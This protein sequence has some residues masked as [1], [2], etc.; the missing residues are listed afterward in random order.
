MLLVEFE[1]VIDPEVN[2][3]AIRLAARLR[4]RAGHVVRDVVSSYCS[5]GVH[6][7]PLLTDLA[8]L[9]R[10]IREESQHVRRETPSSTADPI[11]IAVRYGGNDGPDLNA[12]AEWAR[13]SPSEVVERH[14]SR[15][16]R[17]YMLG[18]VPGFAYMGRVDRLI[19]GPRHRVP[20][21][22]VPAGSVGIAG[23]QTGVYPIATPGGW[24][25]IGQTD[26]VMFDP[27]RTPASLVQP[28]DR[29]RF[30]PVGSV[31]V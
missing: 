11:E 27:D 20:R 22:R 25:L 31:R 19:A 18:F 12:L 28:G 1:Q 3:Q 5:I 13:C 23:E 2:D 4:T 24:Q 26:V 7:D 14:A 6:F 16:Y 29:V 9:E 21:D 8:A 17:V 30:V 10:V 15:I